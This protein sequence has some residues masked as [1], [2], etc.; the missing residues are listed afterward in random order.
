MVSIIKNSKISTLHIIPELAQGGAETQLIELIKGSGKHSVL[1][2][3]DDGPLTSLAKK[4][5]ASIFSAKMLKTLP[6]PRVFLKLSKIYSL[7]N[8]DIIYAWMYHSALITSIWK[9]FFLK[10]DIPLVW[11][12]R[13]S[14]MDTKYYSYRLKTTIYGCKLISR[15]PNKI[16]YN[17]MTGARIH[18]ELGFSQKG[19]KVIFNGIDTKRFKPRL[20]IREKLRKKYNIPKTSLVAVH[21]ARVDPMKD[22]QTLFKAFKLTAEK[23]K[24]FYLVLIGKG[25][26]EISCLPSKVIALGAIE[27]VSSLYNIADISVSSSSFGE[28]FSNVIAESMACGL[29]PVATDVGDAKNIIGESG[30]IVNPNSANEL[31]NIFFK[32]YKLDK[33]RRKEIKLS[34]RKRI[35]KNFSVNLMKNSY[36]KLDAEML[37]RK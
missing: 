25:T 21:V 28:G 12:I 33:D 13:C 6:D 23:I 15:Y 19:K 16:I 35:I 17:S 22:H 4:T 26:K 11:A 1:Q 8:P 9:S 5:E 37:G 14:N 3:L 27:D 32:I 2:L 24:N 34:S 31:S 29:I 18:E 36:K 7:T 10:K 20:N 30:F